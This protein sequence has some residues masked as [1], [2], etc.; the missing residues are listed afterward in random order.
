MSCPR[1]LALLPAIVVTACLTD[2]APRVDSPPRDPDPA[3]DDAPAPAAPAAPGAAA[4]RDASAPDTAAPPRAPA[5]PDAAVADAIARV[6]VDAPPLGQP[7]DY[8]ADHAGALGVGYYHTCLILPTTEVKCWS[9][10]S[11]GTAPAGA[12]A[13]FITSTHGHNCII[14]PPGVL[15][16]I[17]CWGDF[18]SVANRVPAGNHDPVQLASGDMHSCVLERDGSV[19]CFGDARVMMAPPP[20]LRARFIA[21]SGVMTCAIALDDTVVCWGL[22][23]APPPPGLRA[24]HLAVASDGFYYGFEGAT[25]LTAAQ[26]HACAV[27]PEGAVV[28]WGDNPY[29]AA[30][31]PAGLQAREVA[32]SS[33][34]SCALLLDG[35]VRCWGRLVTQDIA[36]P[37]GL[38]AKTIRAANNAVCARREDDTVTC[39]GADGDQHL[40]LANGNRVLSP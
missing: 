31:A 4:A 35:T 11:R 7:V 22:N 2:A 14:T 32:V 17:K 23:V 13:V 9:G 27:T 24:A 19:V 8:I 40:S 16:R 18:P 10:S 34:A 5:L 33:F 20:G 3:V 21:S 29:G 36:M 37:A 26:R 28:C 15:P 38:R 6:A 39:W 12:K 30:R 25:P 1:L